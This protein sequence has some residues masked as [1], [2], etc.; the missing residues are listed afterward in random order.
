MK[1][2]NFA[3]STAGTMDA[4]ATALVCNLSLSDFLKKIESFH[5]HLAPGLVLGGFMVD[6]A[7]E[8]VGREIESDAIVETTHCLPDA[9]QI[10]TPCTIGNGWLKIL[11]WDKFALSLYDKKKL[12]G[13]R[14]YLDLEKSRRF[15]NLFN[16]Y[17]RRVSKKDLPLDVLLETILEAK[18]D[19]LSYQWIRVT[20]LYGPKK[21][22]ETAV[23]PDCKEVYPVHQGERCTAC[24]GQGYYMFAVGR[25]AHA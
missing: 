24:L 2:Y 19:A 11:D 20:Q 21:K 22:H 9:V 16:W 3:K 8:L 6:W 25:P 12:L 17:M 13:V 7:Q 18:R 5:G 23:C 15:P 1:Q 10:F 14:I 4:V